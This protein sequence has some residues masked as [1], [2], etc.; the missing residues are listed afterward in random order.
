MTG[1]E[2]TVA[3]SERRAGD[4]GGGEVPSSS[5]RS[6]ARADGLP[7]PPAAFLYA[8]RLAD[9]TD[10]T[11]QHVQLGNV[12]DL[13]Q[14]PVNGR[15]MVG[16][17]AAQVSE[18]VT[19]TSSGTAMS[20]SPRAARRGAISGERGRADAYTLDGMV[21][22]QAAGK[23]AD[24]GAAIRLRENFNALAVSR[25]PATIRRTRRGKVKVPTT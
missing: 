3:A 24:A 25:R 16:N 18:M 12:R 13:S 20:N 5:L 7:P 23:D 22:K 14:L 2:T 19:V 1:G 21:D 6:V 9:L 8:N 11:A 10:T 17:A 4:R 15:G